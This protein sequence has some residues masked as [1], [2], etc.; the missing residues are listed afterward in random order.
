MF[1]GYYDDMVQFASEGELQAE[2]ATAKTEYFERTGEIFESDDDFE[3]RMASFLEWYVFDREVPSFGMTPARLFIEQ[4]SGRFSNEEHTRLESLA[5][6]T[7]SLFEYRKLKK[8]RL[9]VVDLLDNQSHMVH[10]RREPKGLESGDILEARIVR[11][12]GDL[13]FSEV[14][15]AH[16]REARRAILKAT[17]SFRKTKVGD[18]VELV[19][20]VARLANRC[21]RYKHVDPKQIFSELVTS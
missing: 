11:Y 5:A 3:R 9:Y 2:L 14:W 15:A 18:R 20:R 12:D 19:H 10:E 4:C 13:R 8:E 17:K 16:P 21:Q 1:H 6:S 7:P